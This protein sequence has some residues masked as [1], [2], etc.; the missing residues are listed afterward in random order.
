MA[1]GVDP[2][3]RLQNIALE[4][5]ELQAQRQMSWTETTNRASMF[6]TIV[7][8]SVFG[9]ALVG[10]ATS[11]S[12]DF[13]LV[14]LLVLPVLLFV[15]VSSMGRMGELDQHDWVLVQ[16]LNRLRRLRVELD[17]GFAQYL[18]T[19]THDDLESVFASYGSDGTV[20]HP[21]WTL[22]ALIGTLVAVIAAFMAAI[23]GLFA[24]A[25][26]V[27]AI[28]ISVVTFVVA[29][30]MPAVWAFRSFNSA[31]RRMTVLF[32]ASRDPDAQP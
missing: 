7:G 14:V 29:M 3:I 2:G 20:F 28:A 25:D 12:R 9:L 23:A 32:P 8:A 15:G 26:S 6:M 18:V 21:F 30:V 5:A 17:P 27:A 4:A 1:D 13:L 10:N 24:G 16:G 19:S 31:T 11:F 22:F